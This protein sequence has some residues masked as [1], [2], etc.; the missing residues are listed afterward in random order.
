MITQGGF[1]TF[2]LSKMPFVAFFFSCLGVEM[3]QHFSLLGFGLKLF[4]FFIKIPVHCHI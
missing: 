3:L 4:N 1:P 2:F